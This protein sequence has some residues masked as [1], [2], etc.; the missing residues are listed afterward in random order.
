VAAKGRSDERSRRKQ[1]SGSRRHP[2]AAGDRLRPQARALSS[3]DPALPIAGFALANA[4]SC[5]PPRPPWIR[6]L[7]A[8]RRLA[9]GGREDAEASADRAGPPEA[10][11][12]A[13]PSVDSGRNHDGS[14]VFRRAADGTGTRA[15]PA[16]R[17]AATRFTCPSESS[18]IRSTLL[19]R[20]RRYGTGQRVEGTR[21]RMGRGD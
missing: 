2:A 7:A 18:L 4:G 8:S 12:V 13:Q 17:S 16:A 20:R 19:P 3:P 14:G 21:G 9:A 11:A 1:S 6:R 15:V 5:A 10:P